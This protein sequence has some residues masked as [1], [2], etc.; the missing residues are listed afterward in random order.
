MVE[1]TRTCL[2]KTHLTPCFFAKNTQ[3]MQFSIK[4]TANPTLETALRRRIDTKTKPLGAL[5]QLEKIAL[6]IG[7]IQ[8]SEN[9]ILTKPQIM[10]FAADHGITESGVSLYP[11]EVT[12]QMI[13]N[14][15]QGGAAINVFCKQHKIG[16]QIV[17]AGVKGD[18]FG[19]PKVHN[20]RIGNGTKN[21]ANEAAMQSKECDQA[22]RFG[23]KIV[24]KIAK[25]GTNV[26]GFGEMG[27]GNTSSS[28]VLMHLFTRIS[29]ENCIGRGTG[30]DDAGMEK[31]LQI[32]TE[33]V[34]N[35]QTK[36]TQKKNPT[37]LLAYF[38]GFEIAQICGAMLAAAEQKMVILVDGFI[39]T[40]ALLVAHAMH[41]EVLDYC[42]FSH[43]SDESGH[44][45]MLEFL[46]VTP[47]LKLDLRLGEGTGAAL[48]YPILNSAVNFLAEMASFESANV[49]TANK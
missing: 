33:A 46:K 22:I 15:V 13:L 19:H 44:Q 38:G 23:A 4:K 34:A 9:P 12:R 40:A 8:V 20:Q 17:D 26:I 1:N 47:I 5:G 11:S 6:Q 41:P 18:H 25:K 48:A 24:K 30:L 31:K 35:F 37:A 42:V 45:K 14:F 32:L 3:I 10:V 29:L 36:K 28:A 7:L 2:A 16:L 21:F 49:S 39:A 43:Q 27:I